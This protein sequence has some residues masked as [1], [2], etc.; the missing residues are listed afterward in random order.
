MARRG[1]DED[2]LRA[3]ATFVV[4]RRRVVLTL[5][6]LISLALAAGIARLRIEV[7][8]D[9]SLPQDHP[10]VIA[11]NEMHRV[12]GDK[13]LVVI[14][15]FPKAG[16]A[17]EPGFL[18][19]VAHIT[20]GLE[21]IPGVVLP[22]LQSIASPAMKDV[23]P[24]E[25][26]IS[27]EPLM[28]KPPVT[29]AEAEAVRRRTLANPDNVGTLVSAD[30]DALAIYATFE[31][32]PEIPAWGDLHRAV[33]AVLEQNDDGSFTWAL[34]GPV[35]LA[36]AITDYSARMVYFFP[37]ALLVIGLVH[38]DAFRTVQAMLLPLLTALLA[39]AWA[40]G[41]M[42]W[43]R[44]PLDPFNT[45]TPI[46]ILAVAAGHAVQILKRYYEEL[47][48]TGDSQQA[49]VESLT[50]VG[51][52]MIA[53]G[54]IAALSFL[55]L[56]TFDVEAVRTFGIFTALGIVST[57]AIELTVVPALRAALPTPADRERRRERAT[58]P[59]LDR[60]LDLIAVAVRGRG[61]VRIVAGA[62]I[63]AAV[64]ALLAT[65]VEVDTS[66]KRQ[67]S[68]SSSVYRQDDLLNESFGGTSTLIFLIEGPDEGA[69][70]EPAAL[71]AIDRFEQRI[72]REPGV[73]KALSVVGRVRMLHRALAGG[74]DAG[75]LPATK[76]L[77]SQY[78]FLYTLSG[79][80]DL[81]T[82]VTVDNRMAKLVV[83]LRDDSTRYG[84]RMIA[85]ARAILAEELPPGFDYQI[86]GTLASN[87]ALTDAMVEGKLANILQIAAITIVVASL[88]LRSFLAGLLVAIPLALAVAINFA[89][90]GAIGIPL[91]IMT[92]VVAAMAV[93]IGADYAVYFLFRL[94]EE[95]AG[96]RDFDAA[97]SRTL[98]TSGKAIV[99]V[100]TAIAAGYATLC[101]SGF[102]IH[103]LLGGLVSL[104]MVTSSLATLV[105]L[106]A[107]SSLIAGSRLRTSLLPS[108]SAGEKGSSGTRPRLDR[109]VD[110]A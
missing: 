76:E 31:L 51:R 46:L 93:G 100:S 66:F 40:I 9:R 95:C 87:G 3:Y 104:A 11:L 59:W 24:T 97:M 57:L 54:T 53:A 81:S 45:T 82:L 91:D 84:A 4:R 37:L 90:M 99:F 102:K 33:I 50:R 80:D 14:G 78:L 61:A 98:R 15:L 30:S 23:Q 83:L 89:V 44:V 56:I 60:W 27:V 108:L 70:A 22:L 35:V 62:S 32:T 20:E 58:H 106:S 73:G 94:R 92:S 85:R 39:V 67:F 103:V 7:D 107:L 63:A 36:S 18:T 52:V 68:A 101:F 29:A 13:N 96:E 48:L 19:R 8:P 41:L 6:L 110:G 71:R 109:P 74:T 72:A 49:V 43:L 77:A 28:E 2:W 55:S 79:G 26:G 69:I 1:V 38:F 34:S 21:H 42:G 105:V 16:T 12:F 86:S 17:F 75:D 25:D 10:Y 5:G 65:R 64:C 88:L 47:A